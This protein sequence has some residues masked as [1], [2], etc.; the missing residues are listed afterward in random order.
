MHGAIYHR[1]CKPW[2][3]TFTGSPGYVSLRTDSLVFFQPAIPTRGMAAGSPE[4]VVV[5]GRDQ[6]VTV[7]LQ[8]A[9]LDMGIKR[10]GLFVLALRSREW[11]G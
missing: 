8:E 2:K 6:V 11:G 10:F 7:K 9:S 3:V 4:R 1:I 5:L